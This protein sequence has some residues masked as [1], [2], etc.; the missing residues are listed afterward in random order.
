MG[1]NK[2]FV[3]QAVTGVVSQSPQTDTQPTSIVPHWYLW[4]GPV[5]QPATQRDHDDVSF[6]S[7]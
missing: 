4:D 5:F 3:T 2:S 6:Y 7:N 1:N